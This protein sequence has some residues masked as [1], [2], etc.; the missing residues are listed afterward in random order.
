MPSFKLGRV[1]A[2]IQRELADLFRELKDPRISKLLSIV[3]IDVSGDL[4]YATVYVSAIEGFEKTV[5]SVKGLKNAA[6]FLRRELGMRLK[7]RKTPELRFV[8][9]NSIEH[10]AHISK[11]ID[12][13]P[14]VSESEKNTE[15]D[16]DE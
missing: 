7:L 2:D 5:E 4:S 10:S 16:G 15:V 8:A 13:F 9:D 1:S 14:E 6:G 11:I 3:K 12:S